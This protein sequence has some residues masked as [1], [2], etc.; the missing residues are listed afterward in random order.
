MIEFRGFSDQLLGPR[1]RIT[2]M[3]V[4]KPCLLEGQQLWDYALRILGRRDYSVSELREKLRVRAAKKGEVEEILSRLKIQGYLDDRRFAAAFATARLTNQG[5]GKGRVLRDLRQR[6]VA[7]AV[8]QQA[9]R[10]AYRNTDEQE[11]IEKFLRR[12]FRKVDLAQYLAEAR[13]LAAAYR[14]LRLAGFSSSAS[15][16]VLKRFSREADLVDSLGTEDETEEESS[17]F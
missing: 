14:K 10:Q 11:L 9:V 4:R 6:R 17:S 15:L 3:A 13:N 8:A 5:L 16:Q 2:P 12:K 7:P 1:G